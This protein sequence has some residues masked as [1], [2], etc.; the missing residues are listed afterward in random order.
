MRLEPIVLLGCLT[1]SLSGCGKDPLDV[2]QKAA[3]KYQTCMVKRTYK[4]ECRT[5]EEAMET[6]RLTAVKLGSQTAQIEAAASLG[7]RGV[8]G[9]V[10]SSP[11]ADFLK[12]RKA[13]VAAHLIR[14]DAEQLREDEALAKTLAE[15][16]DHQQPRSPRQQA[17]TLLIQSILEEKYPTYFS[18]PP[19]GIETDPE[20]LSLVCVEGSPARLAQACQR[21]T[22]R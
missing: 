19:N 2:L 21:F 10:E 4:D 5:L 14:A 16:N 7:R 6:A 18:E 15:L 12:R 9:S 11:Y 1:L 8:Q 20:I 13:A 17:E 22:R 3:G